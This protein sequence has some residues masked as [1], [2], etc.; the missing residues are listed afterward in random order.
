MY[1]PYVYL[2]VYNSLNFQVFKEKYW[3][4]KKAMIFAIFFLQTDK[5]QLILTN[6]HSESF[7]S[8][9]SFYRLYYYPD[10]VSAITPRHH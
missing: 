9:P 3:F 5:Y 4:D 1:P 2:L 10:I 6:I 8:Y 7:V